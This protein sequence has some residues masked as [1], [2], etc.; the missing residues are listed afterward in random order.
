MTTIK[1]FMA[2]ITRK[3]GEAEKKNQMQ[4]RIEKNAFFVCTL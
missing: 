2:A 3:P 1:Y 4:K